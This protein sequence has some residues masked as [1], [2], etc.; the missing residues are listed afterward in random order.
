M[1]C[2]MRTS[3]E[4]LRNR[5]SSRRKRMEVQAISFRG[6][7]LVARG[8]S[9]AAVDQAREEVE[10]VLEKYGVTA[11][12][13]DNLTNRYRIL[14]ESGID[15]GRLRADDYA[16]FGI[17]PKHVRAN[18]HVFEVLNASRKLG[19][20]QPGSIISFQPNQVHA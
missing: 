10:G 9:Q 7:K 13:L 16:R 2:Q 20:T 4:H 17:D 11:A 14:G 18:K 1:A 8:M 12:D 19:A 3:V 6:F 15:V 5:E